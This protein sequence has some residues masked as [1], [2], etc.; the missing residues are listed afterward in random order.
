MV[1]MVLDQRTKIQRTRDDLNLIF[2][3]Y[4]KVLGRAWIHHR[5]RLDASGQLNQG[6]EAWSLQVNRLF[7]TTL[8]RDLRN[9]TLYE[10]PP[11]S[12]KGE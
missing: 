3:K 9:E 11:A 2:V 6:Q 7:N 1:A 4:L 12:A 8:L 10:M 5:L